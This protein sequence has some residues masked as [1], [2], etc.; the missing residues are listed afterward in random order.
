M[1]RTHFFKRPSNAMIRMFHF[2]AYFSSLTD[3]KATREGGG[4]GK[5]ERVLNKCLRGEAPPRDPT[6]YPFINHFLCKRYPFHLPSFDNWYQF[7]RPYLELCIPFN[8]R[9]CTVLIGINHRNRTFSRLFKAIKF[10]C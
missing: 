3:I 4:R 1:N 10:I 7:H 9:Y 8:Y 6:P 2:R 5:G